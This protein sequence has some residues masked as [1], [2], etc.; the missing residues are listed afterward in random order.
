MGLAGR[1]VLGTLEHQGTQ[2]GPAAVSPCAPTEMRSATS[3]ETKLFPTRSVLVRQP[4]HDP[5]HAAPK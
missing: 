1:L 4:G 3:R 2:R 5:G